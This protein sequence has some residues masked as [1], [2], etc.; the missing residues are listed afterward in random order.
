MYDFTRDLDE[1]GKKNLRDF[2]ESGKG[3]VVLHHALLELP[4]LDLVVR[5]GGRRPLSPPAEGESPVVQRQG[6]P[7]DL[8]HARRRPPDHSTGIGP[9]HIRTK[10]TRTCG[11]RRR[12]T[13]L[14]TTDNPTSDANL[15]WIGP[16]ETSRVVAIQLGH[17]HSAFEHPSYRALVHNAVLWAAGTKTPSS[18]ARASSERGGSAMKLGLYSITYLGLWYRG[19]ALTLPQ[20]IA[21]AKEFGYD[22]IEIDGKR[23]HGNPLD[24]PT[25]RCREL[26]APGRRRGDR[27]LRRRRQ[28]RLQQP[29]ARGARGADLLSSAS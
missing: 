10:R 14:L 15:A 25:A 5:G 4:D 2:V 13:P 6:R 3:I 18:H 20:M 29:R 21:R 27:D 22:G 26:R 19:E 12:I 11:C 1:A 28:Q 9:F 17:G 8:R 16:C 23:P 7:A 24:W